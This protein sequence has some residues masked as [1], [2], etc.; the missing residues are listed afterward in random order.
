MISVQPAESSATW[1]LLKNMSAILKII[2]ISITV[3]KIKS[4][5]LSVWIWFLHMDMW[6]AATRVLS[7]ERKREDP[8]NEVERE[9]DA[10]WRLH[11]MEEI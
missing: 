1:S 11:K 9:G 8:G 5:P 10:L 2:I 3:G 6:P 7:R 4:D